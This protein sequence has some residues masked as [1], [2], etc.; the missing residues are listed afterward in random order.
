MLSKALPSSY[1]RSTLRSKFKKMA[2]P[3][4]MLAMA[5]AIYVTP[6]DTPE[7]PTVFQQLK[8]KNCTAEATQ[9]S[10]VYIAFTGGVGRV[11]TALNFYTNNP[12]PHTVLYISGVDPDVTVADVLTANSH[13][14][15]IPEIGHSIFIDHAKTTNA[16]AIQSVMFLKE[17]C[18]K[19]ITLITSDYHMPCARFVFER[20]LRNIH[21]N[22]HMSYVSVDAPPLN[23]RE[24]FEEN[25]KMYAV[26]IFSKF[27]AL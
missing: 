25:F 14:F 18:F 11:P 16:N 19:D 3:L 22:P 8:A 24:Q 9:R 20:A 5:G 15:L 13:E 2:R 6:G 26:E 27:D 7:P 4:A 17:H 10:P 23:Q 21:Y 12:D 1:P